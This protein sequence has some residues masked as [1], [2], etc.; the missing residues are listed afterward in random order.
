MKK[1]PVTCVCGKE[2]SKKDAALVLA[3]AS[4]KKS[5]MTPQQRSERA[6]NAANKRWEEEM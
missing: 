1:L 4:H 6:R 2:I 3:S 5:K